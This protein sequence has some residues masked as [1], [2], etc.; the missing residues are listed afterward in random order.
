VRELTFLEERQF[1]SAGCP[2]VTDAGQEPGIKYKLQ[3]GLGA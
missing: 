2:R 1:S 3:K